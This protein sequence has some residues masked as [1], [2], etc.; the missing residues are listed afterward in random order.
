[1]G[2]GDHLPWFY[3]PAWIV[4]LALFAAGP[5]VLPL[6]LKT[7]K[8]S[9]RGRWIFVAAIGLLTLYLVHAFVQLVATVKTTLGGNLNGIL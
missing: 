6:V 5:F 7:P 8:L 1:M 2:Q 9:T 4:A 3:H